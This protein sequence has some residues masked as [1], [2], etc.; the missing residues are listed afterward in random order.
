[1]RTGHAQRGVAAVELAI[2]LIPLLLMVFGITEF[3]RALYVYNTIAK[4]TR[5]AAR[6]VS[7]QQP[8]GGAD[9]DAQC[10]VVAGTLAPC[11]GAAT[12]VP[13]IT[14]AMV[15]VCDWQRCP[16][17]HQAQGA[18]PALNLVT[19]TVSGYTFTSFVPFVTADAA[20][21][22]FADIST[23]MRSNL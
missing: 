5:D 19:V 6:Y 14:T 23:T 21:L 20:N 17:T 2:L 16:G 3:G 15:S 9:L 11:A 1:M 7:T 12:L 4:A 8:G 10:L 13:D 22:I 18:A